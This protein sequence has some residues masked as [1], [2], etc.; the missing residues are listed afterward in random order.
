MKFVE[1][2]KNKIDSTC[3]GGPI[4][5]PFMDIRT[6]MCEAI[7]ERAEKVNSEVISTSCPT[8]LHNLYATSFDLPVSD[9]IQ[10]LAY[11]MGLKNQFSQ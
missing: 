10:L 4:R 11:T 9:V 1:L 2:E 6:R 5:I 3:C 8:C 7:L